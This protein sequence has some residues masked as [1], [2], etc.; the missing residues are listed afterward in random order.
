MVS[1][2]SVLLFGLDFCL[3]VFIKRCIK[4]VGGMEC[5]LIGVRESKDYFVLSFFIFQG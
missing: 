5:E 3:F 4:K 1:K 2:R